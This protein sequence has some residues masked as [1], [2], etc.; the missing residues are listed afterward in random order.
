MRALRLFGFAIGF[1][2]TGHAWADVCE[3]KSYGTLPVEM[4]RAQPTTM[5]QI[6]GVDTHFILDTGAFFSAMSNVHASALKLGT[7]SLPFG[8]NIHAIGG[9][10]RPRITTV[11]DFGIVGTTLHKIDFLVGGSDA[12]YGLLGAN[13]LGFADLEIDLADGKLTLFK[14][15]HCDK[16]GLAY[17]VKDH[18]EYH[19][20]DLAESD[21]SHDWR[22]FLNVK[23]NGTT[24]RALLDSGASGTALSLEAAKRVG[25]D[26]DGPGVEVGPPTQG[27]G[28]QMV[29][30]WLAQIDSFSVG[31]ETI[32]NSRMMVIDGPMG[33]DRAGMVLGADF[34]L[35]HRMF[36]ANSLKKAYFTYNGG[37]VF[38]FAEGPSSG[39]KSA[40]ETSAEPLT[41]SDYA[42][43]G[44]ADLS[45]G[46]PDAALANLSTAISMVP[47]QA[48]FY[49]AR[50]TAQVALK[51]PEAALADLDKSLS[52]DPNSADAL[53]LRAETRLWQGDHEGA[54]ADVAAASVL[55][56][57]G[58]NLARAI[59]RIYIGLGQAASALP[60]LDDWIRLHGDDASLG[61]FLTI[62]CSARGLS[63]RM[64]RDALKD[65]RKA[66]RRDGESPAYLGGVGLVELRLGHYPESIKAYQQALA[67]QANYAWFRYGLGI[68]KIRNGQVDAGKADLADALALDPQIKAFAEAYG[69]TPAAPGED[70]K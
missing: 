37:R 46:Q 35:A 49:V 39:D 5:V 3:L 17:W 2:A 63:N 14:A 16:A 66:I 4:R 42:L 50:A 20:V 24:V 47:D 7:R 1:L 27:M 51:K 43:R 22:T 48:T 25:I 44:Q 56:P 59:A 11:K 67:A 70:E 68:A 45:R 9:A 28:S 34:L 64:L 62:R 65:C 6:N 23:V 26:I 36:I 53:L 58:S 55:V 19:V 32:R 21:N 12:G 41:A 57:A 38:R 54:A 52:L 61:A 18:G 69:L 30:T 13:L 10:V 8:F 15:E 29:K 40:I 60:A 33:S 31:T